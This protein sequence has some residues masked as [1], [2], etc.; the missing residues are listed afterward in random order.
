MKYISAIETASNGAVRS[1]L[2]KDWRNLQKLSLVVHDSETGTDIVTGADAIR[3]KSVL[4]FCS[5]SVYEGYGI[6]INDFKTSQLHNYVESVVTIS[7]ISGVN[8]SGSDICVLHAG[9]SGPDRDGVVGK[10]NLVVNTGRDKIAAGGISGS[11]IFR[12]YGFLDRIEVYNLYDML[13]ILCWESDLNLMRYE[14]VQLYSRGSNY[15]TTIRF[16]HDKDSERF[17][18]KMYLDVMR[19]K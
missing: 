19:K 3:G 15:T 14:V 8:Y 12:E 4:G 1:V 18:T 2:Y 9:T 5:D 13:G 17:F 16:R 10:R 7:G 11:V 6:V